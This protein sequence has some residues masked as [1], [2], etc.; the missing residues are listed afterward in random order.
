[1]ATIFS[2]I[3]LGY[4]WGIALTHFALAVVLFFIVNWIGAKAVSVGYMQMDIVIQEDTAPAFNFLFKVLAPVVFIV[5]SAVFFEAV[6]LIRFN[7]NIYFITIFYW[8]FRIG[9]GIFTSRGKLTNWAE[10]ILYWTVS[11]GLSLWVY[12]LLES[13]D[14]IL[15]S[16]RSLLDQLWILIIIFLYSILNKVQ[17]SRAGTIKRKNNYINSRYKVFVQK[18]DTIVKEYFHNDF[19][20][21]LTYSIM[22]YED[23]NRPQIVR[24]IEYARFGIT[25]K[26]HTLGI[27]QVMTSEYINNE[28]SIRRAMQKIIEDSR[29]IMEHY[30]DSPSPDAN[31]VAFLIAHNYNPGDYKYASEIRDIFRQIST[32]FYGPMPDSYNEFEKIANYEHTT[33]I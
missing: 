30:S 18:Y 24:W 8:L 29:K 7:K 22:I 26:P 25:H 2:E 11:V 6:G 4:S 20:E 17:I 9:W 23:F 14:Q 15:P 21:A 27:M 19:Y 10:Q 31:Y 32:T 3:F 16:P 13:V 28:E 33:R 1:M 5:L 12:N